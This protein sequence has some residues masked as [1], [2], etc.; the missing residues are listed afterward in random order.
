MHDI[1]TASAAIAVLI[2]F[3]GYAPYIRDTLKGKTTP[4]IYSWFVWF[5]VTGIV[6][7]LQISAGAG[8]GAWVSFA[9][10]AICLFIFLLGLRNGNKNITVS[11][12]VCLV[13][14]LIALFLWL[15][16]KQ[17]VLS[18]ILLVSGD[19]LGFIPTVR[20]AWVK[21][22][23][24]TLFLFESNV[25]SNGLGILALQ[26]YS[27]VTWLYPASWTLANLLFCLALI[28]RRRQVG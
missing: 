23:S 22:Y 12:T 27:I 18:I 5:F 11:D 13:L 6:F 24:E 17:P 4:H 3:V 8:V 9:V 19:L 1:K 20:K 14:A 2:N 10:A 26:R 28:M 25:L 21:P 16:V 7:A 15:V